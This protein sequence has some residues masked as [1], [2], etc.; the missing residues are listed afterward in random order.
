MQ[1]SQNTHGTFSF[2]PKLHRSHGDSGKSAYTQTRTQTLCHGNAEEV[3]ESI[4]LTHRYRIFASANAGHPNVL[5]SCVEFRVDLSYTEPLWKIH[6]LVCWGHKGTL[7]SC[8]MDLLAFCQV[9]TSPLKLNGWKMRGQEL[10]ISMCLSG[11]SSRNMQ[12][13]TQSYSKDSSTT[14]QWACGGLS[15]CF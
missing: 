5:F 6:S 10:K 9:M 14:L 13:F 15:W 12:K 7:I 2:T 4:P 11:I 1:P 3:P 8:T